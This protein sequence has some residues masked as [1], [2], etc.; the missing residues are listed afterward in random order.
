MTSDPAIFADD[1]AKRL[2]RQTIPLLE[3]VII[4]GQRDAILAKRREF[5]R[6]APQ[7]E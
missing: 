7:E 6:Y 5:A 2:V 4:I 3:L 1:L